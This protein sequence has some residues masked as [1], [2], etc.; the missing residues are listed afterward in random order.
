MEVPTTVEKNSVIY[1]LNIT[2]LL[3]GIHSTE[4]K[5]LVCS[6]ICTKMFLQHYSQDQKQAWKQCELVLMQEWLNKLWCNNTMKLY[7]PLERINHDHHD[8]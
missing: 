8:H 2:I 7:A 4:I 6:S 5:A 3:W 1:Y